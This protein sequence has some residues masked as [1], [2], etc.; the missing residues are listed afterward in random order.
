MRVDEQMIPVALCGTHR[1]VVRKWGKI[2]RKAFKCGTWRE[3]LEGEAWIPLGEAPGRIVMSGPN[4]F[5]IW[6]EHV[7]LF[8]YGYVLFNVGFKIYES[9]PRS[10]LVAAIG[11]LALECTE[12][13]WGCLAMLGG[14]S[15]PPSEYGNLAIKPVALTLASRVLDR[16]PQ[17]EAL[18]GRLSV[19][20]PMICPGMTDE[21]CQEDEDSLRREAGR[22]APMDWVLIAPIDL[23]AF[24]GMPQDMVLALR[25][26]GPPT[27]AKGLLEW[28]A[29][30]R[31]TQ[32][33]GQ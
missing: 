4:R 22:R 30:Q 16:L 20:G 9:E 31:E 14:S 26:L 32:Q 2:A 29:Q 6:G 19:D 18:G 7:L 13:F 5:G 3:A 10:T 33:A 23:C 8:E 1:T 11:K 28:I 21:E 15:I 17:F 12:E 25:D 24:A 27:Q